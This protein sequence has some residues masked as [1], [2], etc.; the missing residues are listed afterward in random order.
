MTTSLTPPPAER[1]APRSDL[2]RAGGS[3]GAARRRS[4]LTPGWRKAVV[5]VHVVGS[6]GWLG[7]TATFV[8]LTLAL[9][10][11]V[12][13]AVLRVGY[14]IHELM[15]TWLARPAAILT[16]ATGL[17]LAFGTAWRLTR[18]WWVF[19]K[20]VLLVTTVA[21]TVAHSPVRLRYAV[22]RAGSVGTPDYTA[23]QHALV[24][25]AL[26]HVV[27]I[28]TT[29]VLSVY[30]PGGRARRPRLSGPR[31]TGRAIPGSTPDYHQGSGPSAS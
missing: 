6:V 21:V 4:W 13:P 28:G 23:A 30:K 19:A 20:L 14:G 7:V 17:V 31:P 16:L 15:V 2:T 12:D 25:L 26:F 9:L 5:L 11:T 8:V 18:Y 1:L 29:A 22:E 27:M 24:V 10:D 3:A